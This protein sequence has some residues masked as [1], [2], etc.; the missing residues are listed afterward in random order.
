MDRQINKYRQLDKKN[1]YMDRQIVSQREKKIDI[2]L[3][4]REK[5]GYKKKIR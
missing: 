5:G 4:E 2:Y 3:D 1:R